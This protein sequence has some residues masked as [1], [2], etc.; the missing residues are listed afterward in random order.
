MTDCRCHAGKICDLHVEE[1]MGNLNDRLKDRKNYHNSDEGLM[2]PNSID[3]MPV[4]GIQGG[5]VGGHLGSPTPEQEGPDLVGE[6]ILLSQKIADLETAKNFHM[7]C[8]ENLV[9]RL[10]DIEGKLKSLENAISSI[11]LGRLRGT[12]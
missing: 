1:V 7:A 10:N 2:S 6:I 5:V 11:E 8:I 3:D 12:G 9:E 4:G